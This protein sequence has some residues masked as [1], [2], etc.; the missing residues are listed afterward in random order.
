[1]F[2]MADICLYKIRHPAK[3]S[4]QAE[5]KQQ[6]GLSQREAQSSCR[7]F[8]TGVFFCCFLCVEMLRCW[9]M[10]ALLVDHGGASLGRVANELFPN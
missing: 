6:P 9:M 2:L 1:M 7:E 10:W 4:D 5:E 3:H 8:Q